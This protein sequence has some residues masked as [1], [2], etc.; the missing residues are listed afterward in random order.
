MR[1]PGVIVTG[2]V[3]MA[4]II[5]IVIALG[6]KDK[7]PNTNSSSESTSS[8]PA[9]TN[10]NNANPSTEATQTAAAITY[11]ESGFSPAKVTVNSGDS[12]TIKN[13][14]SQGLQFNSNPHP[15]HTDDTDLNVGTIAPGQSQTFTAT[16]KGTFGFHNHLDPS[17]TG[18]IA[19]K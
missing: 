15:V 19:I 7:K 16:K 9:S 3:A 5:G 17:Q 14:S 1:R 18:T 2:L 11:G 12:V 13:T 10:V 8:T 4:L 6:G